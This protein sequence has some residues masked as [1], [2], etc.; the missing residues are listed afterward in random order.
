M[1]DRYHRNDSSDGDEGFEKPQPETFEFVTPARPEESELAYSSIAMTVAPKKTK[2]FSVE[3]PLISKFSPNAEY[4][5]LEQIRKSKN[6]SYNYIKSSSLQKTFEG[7]GLGEDMEEAGEEEGKA[8]RGRQK[9]MREKSISIMEEIME[10]VVFKTKRY[11][12]H[13]LGRKSG[14]IS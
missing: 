8:R 2:Y 4:A 14:R 11:H 7:E 10:T 6:T 12:P 3:K 13:K 5:G 1:R 9:L